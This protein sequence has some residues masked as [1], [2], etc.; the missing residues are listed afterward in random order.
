MTR[1]FTVEPLGR[2]SDL[3]LSSCHIAVRAFLLDLETVLMLIATERL[4]APV[5]RSK[6]G[7]SHEIP[8]VRGYD[9]YS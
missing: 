4:D 2:W 5:K 6:F 3:V 7:K 8:S 1:L 9:Y